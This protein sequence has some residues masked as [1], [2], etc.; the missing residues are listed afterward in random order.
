MANSHIEYRFVAGE[1]APTLPATAAGDDRPP[2][3]TVAPGGSALPFPP[4]AA[5]ST[6]P[7]GKIEGRAAV[8]G[9]IADLPGFRERLSPGCFVG[10]L[11]AKADIAAFL[12]HDPGKLLARTRNKSL[13]FRDTTAALEFSLDL[14]ATS[15]ARDALALAHAGSLGGVSVG[16]ITQCEELDSDGVRVIREA[17]LIEIS[18]VSAWPAYSQTVAVP[19][20]KP[21]PRR[22]ALNRFLE[23][24]KWDS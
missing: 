19:R 22:N 9:E 5:S 6:E 4:G 16:F 3:P 24:V 21:T 17:E 7:I 8:Y 10:S 18:L 20:A 1:G 13:R 11:N 23:T 12:D 15:A 14:P 2:S